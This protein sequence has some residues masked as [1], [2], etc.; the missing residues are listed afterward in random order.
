MIPSPQFQQRYND[1]DRTWLPPRPLGSNICAP[2]TAPLWYLYAQGRTARMQTVPTRA[3]RQL[4][5]TYSFYCSAQ[6]IWIYPSNALLNQVGDGTGNP[7]IIPASPLNE[8]AAYDSSDSSDASDV[9]C[10]REPENWRELSF[11]WYPRNGAAIS[12]ATNRGYDGPRLNVQWP[13]QGQVRELLPPRNHADGTTVVQQGHGGMT[14]DCAVL[15]ALIIYSVTPNRVDQALIY[16]L[17]NLYY[18]HRQLGGQGC[19]HRDV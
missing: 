18:P 13:D 10:T 6:R 11:T 9:E 16:C 19:K 2:S 4:Y 3:S 17:R 5:H 12:H 1:H 8:E 7:R 15:V 14:G